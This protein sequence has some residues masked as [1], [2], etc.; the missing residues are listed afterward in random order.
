VRRIVETICAE[1]VAPFVYA[2]DGV[3]SS[4]SMIEGHARLKLATPVRRYQPLDLAL[5]GRHQVDNA[6]TAARLLEVIAPTFPGVKEAA[7]RT[8]LTD[9]VWPARLELLAANGRP[10]LID[11][12]H[13]PAGARA[14]A[15]YLHEV[16]ARP[17]P[18][19]VGVMA[20][21]Q[22]DA[23]VSA[24]VPQASTLVCTAVSSPRALPADRLADAAARLAP[25]T[26]VRAI[27][28]PAAALRFAQSLDAPIVVVA[29]SLFLAGEIRGAIA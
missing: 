26:T 22:V 2:P 4:A 27:T 24:L 11:G 7:I 17:L 12:A 29:G 23:I 19:I 10:V 15:S 28:P 25:A 13:N 20:D 16:Y 8:A 3:V 5:R 18:I 14:L 9:V 6:V 21:K 1:R